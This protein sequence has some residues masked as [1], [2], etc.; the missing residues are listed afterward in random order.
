VAVGTPTLSIDLPI[1]RGAYVLMTT[2]DA[3]GNLHQ[4]KGAGGG[5][6]A[7]K[8]NSKPNLGALRSEA[9]TKWS[10][11]RAA[12]RD[13]ELAEIRFIAVSIREAY[14]DAAFIELQESDQS[15][16]PVWT[17]STVTNADGELLDDDAHDAML[18]YNFA[19]LPMHV[20]T[21]FDQSAPSI[22]TDTPDPRFDWLTVSGDERSGLQACIDLRRVLE[23]SGD[24]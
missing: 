21:T 18:D 6:F 23:L 20:P 8:R 3:H 2:T 1:G 15:L 19:D 14:P 7:D 9:T 13:A 24:A 12:V 17:I 5:Q 4:G 16:E 22:S 10:A 11:Y